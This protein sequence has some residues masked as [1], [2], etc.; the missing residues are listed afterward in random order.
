[1]TG[2]TWLPELKPPLDQMVPSGAP[3]LAVFNLQTACAA[4]ARGMTARGGGDSL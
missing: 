2:H 4:P 1:M 3:A